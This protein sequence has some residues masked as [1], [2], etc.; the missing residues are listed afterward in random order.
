MPHFPNEASIYDFDNLASDLKK[1]DEFYGSPVIEF[2]SQALQDI[3][4]GALRLDNFQEY[5]VDTQNQQ[6]LERKKQ[7]FKGF[8]SIWVLVLVL[9][10]KIK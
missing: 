3:N 5:F 2:T 7:A 6:N 9:V 8:F 1:V 10:K 4:D